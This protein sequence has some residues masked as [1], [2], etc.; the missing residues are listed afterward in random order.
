MTTSPPRGTKFDGMARPGQAAL[1][2]MV[3]A[4]REQ[5]LSI[6]VK[7][8]QRTR[9]GP[10]TYSGPAELATGARVIVTTLMEGMKLQWEAKQAAP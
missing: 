10:G 2:R 3:R 1:E 4:R 7:T 5:Q 8:L 9:R 6:K